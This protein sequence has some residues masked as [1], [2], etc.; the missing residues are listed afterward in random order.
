MFKKYEIGRLYLA[1]IPGNENEYTILYHQNGRFTEFQ[2]PRCI[3]D[4][5]SIEFL[6]SYSNYFTYAENKD[7]IALNKKQVLKIA[8]DHYD[9][10]LLDLEKFREDSDE[11]KLCYGA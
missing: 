2:N 3:I 6:K 7:K 8:E 1:F 4:L 11:K 10:F 5:A 9:E